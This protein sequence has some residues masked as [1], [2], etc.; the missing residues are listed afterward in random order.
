MNKKYTLYE[1]TI[2]ILTLAFLLP[3]FT[4]ILAVVGLVMAVAMLALGLKLTF[5]TK[6]HSFQ[7]ID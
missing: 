3:F 2:S 4:F 7:L 5:F 1:K 6:G